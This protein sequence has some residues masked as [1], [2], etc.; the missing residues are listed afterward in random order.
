MRN[1]DLYLHLNAGD[2]GAKGRGSH[3]HNDALAIEVSAYGRPFI[4]DPGSYVYNLDREARQRFRSTGYHSTVMVDSAEQNTTDAEIP[5]VMGNHTRPNVIDWQ[6]T[7]ERDL[8]SAEH[9][10]YTRLPNPVRHR[11]TIEFNKAER[12][13]LINDE[14]SGTGTHEFGFSFHIAPGLSVDE[15]DET[16]V[17]ISDGVSGH[18]YIRTAGVNVNPEIVRAF[19]SRNYGHREESSILRWVVITASPFVAWFIIVPSG[20]GEN[21]ATRLELIGRLADN[22]DN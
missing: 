17:K 13:W 3:G 15:I 9:F 20:A 12:Y 19:V 6:T 7:R 11:R 21:D 14:L 4:V 5:F 16:T 10:G 18:L 1:D 22:I 8:V 2:I